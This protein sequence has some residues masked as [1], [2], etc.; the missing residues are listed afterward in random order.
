MART[1]RLF[2]I[3]QIL[4]GATGPVTA[5]QLAEELEVVPRTVYRDIASL[6]AMR[7]PIEGEAGI[8]YIMRRGFDLPP[9]MFTPEELEALFVGMAL[10]HRTGDAGLERAARRAAEKIAEVLPGAA[11]D[12]ALHVSGW[13]AVPNV[14]PSAEQFRNFIRD[15]TEL[16]ISYLDLQERRTNRV[17][18]PLALIYY[19]DVLVL[20]AWCNLRNG[21]RHFRLDRI[22]SVAATGEYFPDRARVLREEWQSTEGAFRE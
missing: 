16:E 7:V 19:V 4:R 11:P 12:K 10:L 15:A 20:A 14:G 1:T 2:E 6:Q 8:G 21:F 9:L 17:I 3:I 5:A 22:G 18:L 13:T